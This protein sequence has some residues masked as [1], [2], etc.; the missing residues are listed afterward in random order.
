MFQSSASRT[1]CTRLR[2]CRVSLENNVTCSCGK[3][4]ISCTCFGSVKVEH[5][6]QYTPASTEVKL[7]RTCVYDSFVALV[8]P[9]CLKTT[10]VVRCGVSESQ[11]SLSH[12]AVISLYRASQWVC[13][14]LPDAPSLSHHKS[15][16]TFRI[17]TL[18]SN[19]RQ[20]TR[21]TK[22]ETVQRTVKLFSQLPNFLGSM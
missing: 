13:V 22:M 6:E 21:N 3:L 9:A 4:S 16:D 18:A 7:A 10:A 11:Q 1:V 8:R 17:T 20:S 5:I 2:G 19:V 14:S 15:H 12:V